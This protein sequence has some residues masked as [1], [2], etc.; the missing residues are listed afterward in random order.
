MTTPNQSRQKEKATPEMVASATITGPTEKT[1]HAEPD[2]PDRVPGRR[3]PESA[4][5][6]RIVGRRRGDRGRRRRT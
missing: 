1:T 6:L 5:Q 2:Q 4:R 3:A